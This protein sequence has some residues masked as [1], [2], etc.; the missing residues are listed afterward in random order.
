MHPVAL[1][2]VCL[3]FAVSARRQKWVGRHLQGQSEQ[4]LADLLLAHTPTVGWRVP[5][6]DRRLGL[7]NPTVHH[8]HE[9][10]APVMSGDGSKSAPRLLL[11]STGLTSPALE[12]RFKQMLAAACQDEPQKI[13]FLATPLVCLSGAP[14]DKTPT[15]RLNKRW[16][17]TKKG[18]KELGK[19]LGVE[20][21]CVDCSKD[22]DRVENCK[23]AI[24]TAKCIWVPGGNTFWLWYHMRR[25]GI[26]ELVRKRVLE[27]G[28]LYVGHSAGAIVAGSTMSTAFWKGWDDPSAG[29]EI[30]ADKVW[31]D[32]DILAG[33]G[34]VDPDTAFFPHYNDTYTELVESKRSELAK[35]TKLVCLTNDDEVIFVSGEEETV[36]A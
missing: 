36:G 11:T 5:S 22:G 17:T 16:T 24:S 9:R 1:T 28:A 21:E 2:S 23:K 30:D 14:S 3:A 15:Q 33:M 32:E 12:S 20:V 19:Q 4:Q 27:D 29:G 26:D 25:T 8:I 6:A 13:V 31:A 34:L 35:D 7:N 10:S 18:A